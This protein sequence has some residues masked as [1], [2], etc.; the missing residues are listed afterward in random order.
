MFLKV[1]NSCVYSTDFS[2]RKYLLFTLF[3]FILCRLVL[4]QRVAAN[5]TSRA[6]YSLFETNQRLSPLCLGLLNGAVRA[7]RLKIGCVSD[8]TAEA[9]ILPG[10]R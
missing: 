4:H 3:D 6:Q 7:P 10:L 2:E 8:P 1:S 9:I 5:F